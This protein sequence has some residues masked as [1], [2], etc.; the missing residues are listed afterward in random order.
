MSLSNP[1]IYTF[2]LERERIDLAFRFST[3]VSREW[4]TPSYVRVRVQGDDLVGFGA[5]SG[6]NDHIRIFIPE[7]TPVTRE[8]MREFPSRE[9][10]P[11]YWGENWLDLEF[12]VHG[13]E[14]V[15]GVW[16]ATAPL[17]S[18]LGVGGPRG[19]ARIEGTPDSWFLVGDETAVP[20]IR[21]Y[22][23]LIPTGAN[24]RIIVEVSDADHEIP[25]D[26]PVEIEYVHRNGALP[27]SAL[28]AYLDGIS[29]AERPTGDV[30]V[31][32]AAEQSVVKTG[33]ALAIDRWGLDPER[34]VIKGFWKGDESG[35]SY[36]APH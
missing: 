12:A 34:M 30:F 15:A 4:I 31:F 21:R 6:H 35:S 9:F 22:A 18:M 24:A 20:Q 10:T 2:S 8:E 17:G 27:T 3:L 33:R 32:I 11:L 16:A 7:G 26:S 19:T 13:D 5:H 36:H 1:L 14:G 23:D 28:I 25:I 29:A